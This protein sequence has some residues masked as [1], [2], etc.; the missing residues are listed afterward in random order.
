MSYVLVYS[1][2]LETPLSIQIGVQVQDTISRSL[3]QNIIMQT[4]NMTIDS[5]NLPTAAITTKIIARE[6]LEVRRF[7]SFMVTIKCTECPWP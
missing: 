5:N 3:A 4:D 7:I 1:H 2:L 6:W